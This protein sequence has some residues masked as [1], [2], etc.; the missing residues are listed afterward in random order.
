MEFAVSDFCAKIIFYKHIDI[1]SPTPQICVDFIIKSLNEFTLT[2]NTRVIGMGVGIHG[3][4]DSA[5]GVSVYAPNLNW[6]NINIKALIKEH[7]DIP[8]MVDNDVRLMA[9]AQMWFGSSKNSDDFVLLYIGRGVGSAFVIDK[10]LIRGSN[11]A[12]GEFGHTIIDPDGPVCECGRHGCLQAFTNEAAML[13]TLKE[14]LHKSSILNENS[15]CDDIV[16]A[17]L[18]HSDKAATEVINKEI[19]Y[20]AIGI[21]NIINMFNPS[22]IVLASDIKDFDIAVASRLADEVKK[23]TVT[24]GNV[25]CNISFSLLGRHSLLNGATA[26]V[27]N[28][29]YENPSVLWDNADTPDTK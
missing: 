22:L 9:L 5:D 29:I 19:K 3:I 16:D 17:Y 20:L 7:T 27:L 6:R 25:N 13:S 14:N 4:V 21:S 26:L 10:K 11:D 28:S 23:Y 1:A 18:N 15:L 12:A 24:S 8:V 2:N